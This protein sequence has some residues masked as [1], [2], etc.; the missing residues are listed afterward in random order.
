[1]FPSPEVRKKIVEFLKIHLE[2]VKLESDETASEH[3]AHLSKE[4]GH[5]IADICCVLNPYMSDIHIGIQ[6]RLL[7]ERDKDEATRATQDV[8]HI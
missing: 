2:S 6:K 3:L 1:M 5:T 4:S 8:A 7:L